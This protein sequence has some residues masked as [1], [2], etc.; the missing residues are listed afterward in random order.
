MLEYL[1]KPLESD[2]FDLSPKEWGNVLRPTS[3]PSKIIDGWGN[4]RI[5]IEGCEISFSDEMVGIQVYFE[6]CEIP[7]EKASL[8]VQEICKE[9][10]L[11]TG[12]QAE[13]ITL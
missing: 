3:F 11:K 13:V 4:L 2:F 6:N 1:I 12:E 5:E 10:I 9:L 7:E 8:I